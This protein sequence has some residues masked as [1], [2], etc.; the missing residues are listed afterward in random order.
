MFSGEFSSLYHSVMVDLD[1]DNWEYSYQIL[2][3]KALVLGMLQLTPALLCVLDAYLMYF[4][5]NA[6]FIGFLC[7]VSGVL[8]SGKP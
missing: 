8:P 2:R 7:T 1:F 6:I 3:N 4:V 5:P